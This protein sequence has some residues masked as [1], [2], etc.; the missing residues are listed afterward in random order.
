MNNLFKNSKTF[1]DSKAVWII[2]SFLDP[3]MFNGKNDIIA[4]PVCVC[5]ACK[6]TYRWLRLMHV[7]VHTTSQCDCYTPDELL[8]EWKARRFQLQPW[9]G[10][11]YWF[12][13]LSRSVSWSQCP[14]CRGRAIIHRC[15]IYERKEKIFDR[16]TLLCSSLPHILVF[17]EPSTLLCS[18]PVFAYL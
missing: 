9:P 18:H 15:G 10:V 12:H 1:N 13:M 7:L 5:C 11:Y 14:W 8:D 17:L 2:Q 6:I 3:H 4:V 16:E